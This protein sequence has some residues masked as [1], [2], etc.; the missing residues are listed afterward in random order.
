MAAPQVIVYTDGGADPNPGPG[1]WGVVLEHRDSGR[2]RELSGSHPETTNNRMELTAAIRALEALKERC[3]VQIFTD[4][5]YLKNGITR[6]LPGWVAR[7]WKRKGGE[8]KNED[9]WRQ[10]AELVETHDI[11]W[12]WVKGHAGN[13][14][15]ERADALA[16]AALRSQDRSG[17]E[18]EADTEIHLKV[19]A[20]GT[21][22]RWAALIRSA[23]GE[24][25]VSRR[26]EPGLTANQLDILS[27]CQVLEPLPRGRR[28]V[29]HT[30]SEYLKS[31]A[32][33][34]LP[35]WQRKNWKTRSGDPVKNRDLWQRL[36]RALQPLK[37]T[38]LRAKGKTPELKLLTRRLESNDTNP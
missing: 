34:W 32:E 4:S 22:S 29:V 6:W 25:L 10:L 31:G 30:P 17:P 19:R 16:T 36:A 5:T 26:E 28:V 23:D 12:S 27:A 35:G 37:I 24:N 15:N 11:T 8:L 20:T 1:G 7:G 9:L 18:I 21:S 33:K 3:R 38:W 14:G 2:T 13:P